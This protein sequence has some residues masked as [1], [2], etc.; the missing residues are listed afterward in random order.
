[1]ANPPGADQPFKETII[2]ILNNQQQ[3]MSRLTEQMSAI[4]ATVQSSSRNEYVLDSLASNITE[5]NYDLEKGC[6]FDA[7]FSRYADLFEKDAAQLDDAAKVRLLLRKLNPAAH[8]RYTSFILPKLSKEFNFAETV[9]KLQSIFGTPVSTFHRRYQ[10]LQTTKDEDEDFI[11][12]SCKVNRACVDFKLQELKEDQFKCL[13]FVC[14]LKGPKDSDIR[15]RL[16]SKINE[17]QDISLEKVVDECKSLINLKK[18]SVLIGNQSSSTTSFASNAVRT[19]PKQKYK[20]R[21]DD[22]KQVSAPKSPCWACGGMHFSS[23]CKFKEHKCRDCGKVGHRE[24][25]CACFSAKSR[26]NPKKQNPKKN[27]RSS[28]SVIVGNVKQGRRYA[29]VSINGVPLE[30]Q[31]DSGSDITIISKENWEKAGCPRTTPPDCEAKTAS[32]D[33]LNISAMFAATFSI[34]DVQ[35]IGKCYICDKN[36]NLNVLGSD[37]MDQFGLWDVPLSSICNLVEAG[38]NDN[39][40]AELKSKFPEVFAERTGL[41][42]KTQVHLTLKPDAHPVF[43]PK[44][45]VAYSMESIVEDE[46]KRL[47]DLG[48]ITPVSYS[49]WAAPIVVVRKPNRTVRIC[50]D[51]STGL[52]SALEPNSHPLPLPEDIFARMANCTVFGHIDLSDAY[53]QVEVDEQSR[54]LLV[55]NTHK[56]L[57]QFNRLSPG[58]RTAPGEFQQIMDAMLSGLKHTCPYL[59]DI[60]VGGRTHQELK[61][62]LQQVLQRLQDYGFT[63]KI[64]KCKFFMKQVRYLA[65]LL[66]A[67]GIRPDPE[68]ISAIVNMPPPHDVPTLRSYLGAINYYGKYI[69]EMRMLRQPL[70]ELLKKGASF[71]WSDDCQRSFERFKTILQSPLL[72]THYN[73]AMD[74][75]V[76]ADA[77]NIG[78]GARI[79]HR[80]PDGSEKA[81]YHASRSLTPAESG[82]SQIEKEALALVYAV[83]KFHRMIYG[84][85]FILQTDHKPLIAIFGS[86]QGIPAYTA[87]RLQRWALTMLLYDFKIEHISTDNFGHADILSRLIN[88][89]V[90]PDEDYVVA[91]IELETVVCNIVHQ[92]IGFLPVT[93]K[94]IA[95]ETEKDETLQKVRSYTMEGWPQSKEAVEGG[96]EVQQFYARRDSLSTA[97]KC[98]MYA[99]RIVIP[100]KLQKRVLDQLHKGHPGIE[101]TRSLARNYVYWPGIDEHITK[102]VRSCKECSSVAKTDL[103]TTLE[104]WPAPQ[105]PWQRVHIDYAGPVNDTYFLVL[106]DALSKWP[107]VIATKR[108]TT[109]ATIEILRRIFCRFGMPEVL[110]SD[111]GTQFTSESFAG[112]CESNGIVHLKT[113]PFHPQSN[114]QAER[115]VDTFKRT[116]KKIQAGGEEMDAAIETFL[117]CY[118]STP[119]RSAPDGK[120]PAEVLLG[121]RLRTSLELV[122]PPSGST[123]RHESKQEL[124]FNRKHGAKPKSFDVK[125]KVY[126]KLHRGNNWSWIAGEI[127]E[128]IGTVLYNVWVPDRQQL[129]RCHSNQLRNRFEDNPEEAPKS[130]NPV[131]LDLLLDTWGLNQATTSDGSDDDPPGPD[132]ESLAQLRYEFLRSLQPKPQRPIHRNRPQEPRQQTD[133]QPPV[134]RTPRNRKAPVRYEPYHLY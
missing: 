81:I 41:C 117:L 46:L 98:L 100:K 23:D 21:F 60:L 121:R 51:F 128:R 99:E 14:G 133:G 55:I 76:S 50:A 134:R 15:M 88:S 71:H 36:L 131:P 89:H 90:K 116:V 119:C 28:K 101:R 103:K 94:L 83:T 24:G 20:G 37:A 97:Q 68:K 107:E 49:D 13:I 18:D 5:F 79:A 19:D 122:L 8:E 16:L 1:M 70:D 75:V 6:S 130:E 65:Q 61:Q 62:N 85:H 54:K 9:A 74:I 32:G 3:L 44:R 114:G 120:S 84:R 47:E 12:Y 113:A 123:K 35:K 22:Q 112:Y 42:K 30:L 67:E 91:S 95:A 129:M 59:D 10:C 115:F 78:I 106:V 110:V 80:L 58:I 34:G 4:Q 11:S 43:K 111:N 105:K 77:S 69:R 45:P 48:I 38:D 124:Q 66:D 25:Y 72:L 93:Y 86:K 40:L 56:G 108:I 104:S 2:Q 33:K 53:L 109:A 87:N 29:R 118:R 73:P 31:L 26:L 132:D 92:S 17:T 57:Y 27:Q 64:E 63:V 127:V 82:Y 125:D 39:D 102:L 126:A 52:N 96:Q 7:W